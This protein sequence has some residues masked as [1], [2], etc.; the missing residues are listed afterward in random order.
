MYLMGRLKT[1]SMN[2]LKIQKEINKVIKEI[3]KKIKVEKRIKRMISMNK[4]MKLK[5]TMIVNY[6]MIN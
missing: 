3:V 6:W 2:S 1:F 5:V 4:D